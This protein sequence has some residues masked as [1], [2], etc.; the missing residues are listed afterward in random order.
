MNHIRQICFFDDCLP[1]YVFYDQWPFCLV[2]KRKLYRAF[3]DFKKA[4]DR[5]YRNGV[6]Y[7]LCEIGASY[8]FVMA[9]KAIY[10]SVKVYEKSRRKLSDCFESLVG[11]KHGKP[12]SP[13]I[14][15]LFLNALAVE[16]N[17]NA[18]D[19]SLPEEFQKF[20]LLFL[21]KSLCI[22]KTISSYLIR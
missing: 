8:K 12:L 4:F 1:V 10:N 11:V 9:V 15:I 20:M 6:W 2:T 3:I 7:K 14:I 19:F 16:L 17:V 18:D 21:I 13:V 5:V 22:Q